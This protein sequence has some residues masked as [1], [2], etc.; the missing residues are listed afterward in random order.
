MQRALAIDDI[1]FGHTN[2]RYHTFS[3]PARDSQSSDIVPM[4]LGN[5][6]NYHKQYKGKK[7]LS[8]IKCFNCQKYGHYAKDCKQKNNNFRKKQSV[9]KMEISEPERP[10]EAPDTESGSSTTNSKNGQGTNKF[11]Y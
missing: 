6:S 5:A 10:P 11:S 4:E 8:Q 2:R 1:V 9:N 3:R 7:D